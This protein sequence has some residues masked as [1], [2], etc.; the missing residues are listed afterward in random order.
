MGKYFRVEDER[1]AGHR[2]GPSAAPEQSARHSRALESNSTL[3]GQLPPWLVL[4]E[5]IYHLQSSLARHCRAEPCSSWSSWGKPAVWHFCL[6]RPGAAL[7]LMPGTHLPKVNP[8]QI[9]ELCQSPKGVCCVLS[10]LSRTSVAVNLNCCS[11]LLA[12]GVQDIRKARE[13]TQ[14]LTEQCSGGRRG[15]TSLLSSSSFWAL[16]NTRHSWCNGG[17]WTLSIKISE[18]VFLW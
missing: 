8:S 6:A 14:P 2:Y 18:P 17:L 9:A 11:S 16:E 13:I 7:L 4:R 1:Q 3:F 12:T 10:P 15:H 5:A